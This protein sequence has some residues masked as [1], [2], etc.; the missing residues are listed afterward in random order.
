MATLSRR[1]WLSVL[2]LGMA[3]GFTLLLGS[4]SAACG[5]G[6]GDFCSANFGV[7]GDFSAVA[8]RTAASSGSLISVDAGLVPVGGQL[9]YADMKQVEAQ[10]RTLLKRSIDFRNDISP[11]QGTNSF[12]ALV[13]KFDAAPGGM[14][15]SAPYPGAASLGDRIIQADADLAQARDLYAFLAVYAAS[16]ELPVGWILHRDPAR[17]LP[18]GALRE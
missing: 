14:N 13:S 1:T 6:Q 11:Y 9:A 2:L 17:R 12:N 10:A 3:L 4:A 16:D 18:R 5:P 15:F 7:A 8:G